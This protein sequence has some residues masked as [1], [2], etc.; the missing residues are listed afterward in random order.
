MTITEAAVYLG[1][2]R[3][4]LYGYL[5]RGELKASR[6][7]YKFLLRKEDIDNLFNNPSEFRVPTREKPVI[8][9]FYTTAEVKGKY[10][11]QA[12]WT[13]WVIKPV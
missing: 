7:G 6:L 4:T 8:T 1:V 9:D 3:P 13:S 10:Q 2:T 11:I 5:R 12:G